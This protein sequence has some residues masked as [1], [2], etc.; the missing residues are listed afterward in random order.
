MYDNLPSDPEFRRVI[1][2]LKGIPYT[3]PEPPSS[4]AG[5]TVPAQTFTAAEVR[6][7]VET[8][9]RERMSLFEQHVKKLIAD[10]KDLSLL[11]TVEDLRWRVRD[12]ETRQTQPV[13]HRRGQHRLAADLF[14][15]L[16]RSAHQ[17]EYR[18]LQ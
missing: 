5:P 1:C 18:V 7:L 13:D 9:V 10:Q 6:A 16:E 4:I 2:K 15:G 14:G 11:R 3:D 8:A 12:L 17:I